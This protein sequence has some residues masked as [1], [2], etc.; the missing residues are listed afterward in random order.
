M[1]TVGSSSMFRSG[2]AVV[3]GI[4]LNQLA[5]RFPDEISTPLIA[6][7]GVSTKVLN[8]PFFIILGFC[9]GFQPVAG[10]NWGAK[11]YD[12]V[13]Q[14][15]KFASTVAIIGAASMS[16]LF[17][18]FVN[19]L[20]SLFSEAGAPKNTFA[21]ICINLIDFQSILIIVCA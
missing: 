20:I 12:R 10:F 8:F 9:T 18:I 7:I 6:G 3:A 21:V 2:L 13:R 1:V 19:P 11:R 14:S 4:L 5:G 15:Y 16:A 17:I